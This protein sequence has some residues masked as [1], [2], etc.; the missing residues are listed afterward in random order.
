MMEKVPRN[1][2]HKL[3]TWVLMI[4]EIGVEEVRKSKGFHD[5]PLKGNLRG[6]RSIRLNK[7]YRAIYTVRFGMIVIEEVS[8]HEY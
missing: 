6:C 3:D 1:I 7:S 4:E 2:A 8:K 5:E